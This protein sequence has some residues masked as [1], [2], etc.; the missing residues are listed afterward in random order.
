MI[1]RPGWDIISQGE[2]S[3]MTAKA[4]T[5]QVISIPNAVSWMQIYIDSIL[6]LYGFSNLHS[7]VTEEHVGTTVSTYIVK[8][9]KTKTNLMVFWQLIR[10]VRLGVVLLKKLGFYL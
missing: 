9:M 7:S 8:N 2:S 4:P 6:I 1:L 5:R 10:W 3:Q